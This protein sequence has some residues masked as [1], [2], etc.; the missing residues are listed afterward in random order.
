[1]NKLNTVHE[2]AKV[3]GVN[4]N[5]VYDL[6]KHGHLKALKLGRLKVSTYE[7]DDFIERNQNKDFSDLE[8]IRTLVHNQ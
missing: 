1:M 5:C 4:N 8:N 2:A 3:L 7:L 6:I